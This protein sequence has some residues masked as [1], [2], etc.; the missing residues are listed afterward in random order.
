MQNNEGGRKW[1][2][3][4]GGARKKAAPSPDT[5]EGG[6]ARQ[7]GTASGTIAAD[8]K[9]R[10]TKLSPCTGGGN[11]ELHHRGL[12]RWA[13]DWCVAVILSALLAALSLE[14]GDKGAQ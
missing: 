2:T 1:L 8:Q 13:G 3:T 11:W 9:R 6:A 10:E 14:L 4:L 12:H 5:A 7:K